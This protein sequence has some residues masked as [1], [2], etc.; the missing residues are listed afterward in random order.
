[1]SDGATENSNPLEDSFDR[2]LAYLKE[3]ESQNASYATLPPSSS[4]TDDES[5]SDCVMVVECSSPISIEDETTSDSD[6][7]EDDAAQIRCFLD[8]SEHESTDDDDMYNIPGGNDV[9]RQF[10]AIMEAINR[11]YM[12]G[13]AYNPKKDVLRKLIN[14]LILLDARQRGERKAVKE[15]YMDNVTVDCFFSFE[16]PRWK[17]YPK[18]SNHICR[19]WIRELMFYLTPK[20]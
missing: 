14:R 2:C 19:R 7:D 1:M 6:F 20:D 18:S 12:N 17:V 5:D 16:I 10:L 13:D 8:L 9:E 15:G 4:T 3:S 11:A